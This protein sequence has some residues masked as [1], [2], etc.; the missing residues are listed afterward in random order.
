[1]WDD[2][3]DHQVNDYAKGEEITIMNSTVNKYKDQTQ[4]NTTELTKIKVR[5]LSWFSSAFSEE[6]YTKKKI[7]LKLWDD[8]IDQ[9]NDYDKGEE[10]TIMNWNKYKDQTQLNTTE[11]TKI[12]VRDLSWFFSAF[13]KEIYTK[14]KICL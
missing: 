1:M 2:C 7:C 3:I 12:Q 4:L 13:S 8:C 10:I 14:K 6:I 9:V 5:A 11:L